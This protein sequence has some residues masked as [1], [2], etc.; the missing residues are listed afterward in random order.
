MAPIVF[1]T[2]GRS[3]AVMSQVRNA[4][5]VYAA[6]PPRLMVIAARAVS[7]MPVVNTGQGESGASRVRMV[8]AANN[9]VGR[10]PPH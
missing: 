6:V 5:G 7:T 4:S 3:R 1:P 8:A 9:A 10:A 2:A